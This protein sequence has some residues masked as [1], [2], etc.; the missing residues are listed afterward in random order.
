MGKKLLAFLLSVG[1]VAIFW[2]YLGEFYKLKEKSEIKDKKLQCVSYAPFGKDES[3]FLIDKGFKVSVERVKEDLKLISKYS[4]CI[5]TYSSVGL[6][7]IPDIARENGLKMLM[8]AWI[9]SDPKANELEINTLVKLASAN[10]DILQGVVVGNEVLLRREL[11][12]E[13]LKKYIKRVKD[14]L[15]SIKITYADVWEFWLKY[16]EVGEVVDFITIHILPYWEDDPMGIEKAIEHL[17]SVR[18][19]VGEIM[20]GREILIGE[21]GWPSEG[22]IREDAIPSKINQAKFIREFV[23]L[24]ERQGWRYNVIEA[25]DQPWK[26]INEGAVGGYW[27][28]FDA[29]RADKSVL[30]GEVTNFP[31]YKILM[32]IS[33]VLVIGAFGYIAR[34]REDIAPKVMIIS[35][36]FALLIPLQVEQFLTTTRTSLE[37]SW[38]II[39]IILHLLIFMI[40]IFYISKDERPKLY[41][42][43]TIL[44]GGI[45]D[46]SMLPSFIFYF[47][48]LSFII[49]SVALGVE[50]RYRN[51][52]IYSYLVSITTFLIFWYDE[53][54]NL[55]LKKEG[56]LLS[57][58]LTI[59]LIVI[60][61]NETYLN[62]HSNIWI[63]I[64]IL[65]LYLL[66]SK[67]T[68]FNI[69][70]F[71]RYGIYLVLFFGIFYFVRSEILANEKYVPVC[72][73]NP[74]MFI[75]N[76]RSFLGYVIYF[77]ILGYISAAFVVM[78]LIFKHRYVALIALF[79]SICSLV[80]FNT[81]LGSLCFV[82]A[83]LLY[84]ATQKD[85]LSDVTHT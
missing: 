69:S 54:K 4:E 59:S 11:T 12:G 68:D 71:L 32:A 43:D 31:N 25:F 51:F 41:P 81:A 16:P 24:A 75:C 33:L 1:T 17:A 19:E 27:G 9:N 78:T 48:L 10:S 6:E 49:S 85:L 46:I 63:L 72:L 70:Q 61:I 52:E 28:L 23:A 5:R 76:L 62:I 2:L 80:L 55:I 42:I 47:T 26:R 65:F 45:K 83:S 18:G 60:F 82:V 53:K 40:A 21:T 67:K 58:V 66:I 39:S 79:F 22:R 57:L 64:G 36:L 74:D 3:P 7:M 77:Q 20:K 34:R 37:L 35:T 29:D 15:P 14:A 73:G 38:A 30:H 44:F 84:L 56:V 8:G 50:G 13:E